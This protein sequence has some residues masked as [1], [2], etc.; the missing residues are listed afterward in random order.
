MS[1]TGTTPAGAA[2]E[3][4]GGELLDKIRWIAAAWRPL[5]GWFVA[6]FLFTLGSTAV[7]LG[8]P[9]LLRAVID[10]LGLALAKDGEAQG[11]ADVTTVLWLIVLLGLGRIVV[12]FYPALRAYLNDRIERQTREAWFR[13]LLAKDDGFLERFRTGDLVTR[14]TDDLSNYPRIAWYCCSGIFRALDSTSKLLFCLSVMLWL[15]WRLALLSLVP[16]PLM[17]MGFMAVQRRLREKVEEQRRAISTTNDLLEASF[18]GIRIVKAHNAEHRQADALRRQLDGRLDVELDV[19]RLWQLVHGFYHSLNVVGQAV[20]VAAGG[21][22][23]IRG[24]LT[25][26]TFYAF[27]VYL[28]MLLGPLLDIPNLFVTG[29]QAFVSIDRIEEIRAARESF[30]GGAFG[31]PGTSAEEPKQDG[32]RAPLG[33]I[34]ALELSDVSLTFPHLAAG[35][36]QPR[37]TDRPALDGISL[38]IRRGERVAILGRLGAGKSTLLRVALGRLRPDRG[39]VLFN[40]RPHA[41]LDAR[42]LR[43]RLGFVPQEATLLSGTVRENVIFGRPSD[44]DRLAEVLEA[45]GLSEEIGRLPDGVETELGQ[46]GAGLSGGQRQRLSIARALYGEPAWFLFDD[47]T[48]ALDAE[49]EARLWRRLAER[50]PDATLVVVTHR[51]A[52]ARAMA[53]IVVM[54]EGRVV[55]DGTDAELT[56]DCELYREYLEQDRE[57]D[58]AVRARASGDG[59]GATSDAGSAPA[60][61]S[62]S[63]SEGSGE[64]SGS[65]R[66]LARQSGL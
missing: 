42:E 13:K 23:V 65:G 47:L 27:F 24:E 51:L 58:E 36:D 56:R 53:R 14:L 4:E 7:T 30:E 25:P 34:E 31:A 59:S 12:S 19:V 15:D 37:A 66:V 22:L 50:T 63:A 49:N 21:V 1:E 64:G 46:G 38:T 8:Y 11:Q 61:A 52:T 28:G 2:P 40:G 32:A 43:D 20:V 6:L 45:V 26:G 41:E 17:V 60:E 54:D 9:L 29:R 44:E 33:P 3:L 57:A 62:E 48:S 16:L 10:R 35:E 39:E 18:S 5:R 55:A